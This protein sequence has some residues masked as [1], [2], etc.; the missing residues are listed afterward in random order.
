M[1]AELLIPLALAAAG[2]GVDMYNT[3]RAND[4]RDDLAAQG[5]RRQREHQRNANARISEQLGALENSS[6]EASRDAALNEY[7]TQLRSARG[8]ATGAVQNVPGASKRYAA[9]VEGNQAAI[10][11]FGQ[12]VA[13]TLSRIS[14]A[15]RQRQQEAIGSGRMMADV[16]GVAR[17]ASGDDYVNRLRIASVQANPWLTGLGALLKAAGFAAGA[18]SPAPAASIA[19]GAVGGVGAGGGVSQPVQSATRMVA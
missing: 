2:T 3:K 14:A 13:G 1:G 16:A 15:G 9:D 10:G 19:E 8:S 5:L 12:R 17:D 11:N 18:A 6:P 4:K 7:L